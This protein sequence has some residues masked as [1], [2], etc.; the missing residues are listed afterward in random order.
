ML[1][2]YL[3]PYRR[4][5]AIGVSFKLVEVVFDLLTPLV[6]A[7]M[8]D[9]GVRDH[10]AH[11]VIASGALLIVFALI[12]WSFTMVCQ[13]MAALVSQGVGTQ[14]R[15]DL[16]ERTHELSAQQVDAI[17][18]PALITRITNDV[19]QIQVAIALGI[20]QLVRFP[21]IALGAMISAL[22]I[23]WHLGLI[24]LACTPLIGVIF[25]LVMSRSVPLFQRMQQLLDSISTIG[26]EALSGVRVIRAFRREADEKRR[27][28]NTATQQADTAI[29]VGKL[30]ALLN[31]ST[32]LVMNL[33]IVAI[34]WAGGIRVDAGQL[35]QGEVMAFVNYMMQ[36]L[37]SVAYIANLV[38]VFTRASASVGRIAEVI[39]TSSNLQEHTR[40]TLELDPAAPILELSHVSFN[41]AGTST[42]AL[43]DVTLT[44]MP[45]QTLGVIGGT[46]SGKS[47]LAHLLVR[48]YDASSGTVKLFGHNVQDYSFNQLRALVSFVPQ[49]TSLLSGSIRSNLLWRDPHADDQKLW[50]ALEDAQAKDFVA[51]L[52]AGLD[53]PVEAGGKN[54]SGGQRQR[55]T[56][57]RALV[58]NPR[59]CVLDD[60][61][62]AL[63]FKTDAHLRAALLKKSQQM[64][65]VV[66][67]QRVSAI[68]HADLIVVLDHG[69]V[70]GIG[71]HEELLKHSS[72]YQEIVSSQ[73][74]GEAA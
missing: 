63:D 7:H 3:T 62:S 31:P 69:R 22:L 55:L 35:T 44:L 43:T 1:K 64:S 40:D 30:S 28:S 19:N 65:T 42:Q 34:L 6:V 13:R 26:R 32:F 52:K 58:G 66:I 25:F 41:Y 67:S 33:G 29:L 38:V 49:H 24:F 27:F 39:D 15:K 57:A 16:F 8:I 37:T 18:A 59:L 12:G 74:E 9:V 11:T 21:L 51:R 54:F 45:G 10:D 68:M 17:G 2:N 53:A 73:L 72:L 4:Q 56:I 71:T 60:A 20:R 46:G 50:A 23:D 48:L 70:A 36:T 14:L 61:A 47:T 5:V